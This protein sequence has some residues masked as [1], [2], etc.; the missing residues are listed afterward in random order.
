MENLV[1]VK[2]WIVNNWQ[3]KICIFLFFIFGTCG[4]IELVNITGRDRYHHYTSFEIFQETNILVYDSIKL[5]LAGEVD[6]YIKKVAESSALSGLVIVNK[7]LEYDIDICF[8]L[9]QGEQES[10]FGTQGLARKTNSVFNIFAF[11]GHEYNA[12]NSNGKYAHPNDCI[13]PYL[14]LLKRDYL[15]G[16][17]TEYD[18]LNNYVNKNGMRYA[19]AENYEK[20]LFDKM[21]KIKSVTKIDSTYQ[22]LKKQ[23]LIIGID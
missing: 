11:D 22:E 7:C 2:S 9:A 15:V 8:V 12:I 1:K 20:V 23:A 13:E 19:S 6:N 21:I 14:K 5:S 18:M 4:L 3:M 17:K 16:G 10:H